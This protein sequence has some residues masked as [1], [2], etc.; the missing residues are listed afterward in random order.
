MVVQQYMGL[1]A[2]L[3]AIVFTAHFLVRLV[4]VSGKNVFLRNFG[5]APELHVVRNRHH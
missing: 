3:A 5:L 4:L 2:M 1:F